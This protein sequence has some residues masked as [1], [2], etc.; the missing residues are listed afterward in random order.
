MDDRRAKW[1]ARYAGGEDTHDFVPSPPLPE[2]LG[3]VREPGR[4]LDLACGAGRHALLLA[5]HGFQVTALDYA[6]TGI[7][8]LDAEAARRGLAHRIETAVVDLTGGVALAPRA[9]DL[10]TDFYFLE[11][12]LFDPIRSALRPGGL[13]V[14]AI[15]VK[16]AEDQAEH[17][18]LLDPGELARTVADWG[19]EL[20]LHREGATREH[21]HAH[22]T[23]EL[24]ARAPAL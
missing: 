7:A 11:R 21:G 4:A 10:V 14:A 16:S 23:A 22:A 3:H 1:S 24:I 13:F 9:Y 20:L 2:A 15:H 19:F 17:R 5:E 12:T 18:F 6:E 8:L